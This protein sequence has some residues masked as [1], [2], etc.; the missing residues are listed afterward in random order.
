MGKPPSHP[1]IYGMF[2]EINQPAIGDPRLWHE[3]Q[4]H[5]SILTNGSGCFN[6]SESQTRDGL[7]EDSETHWNQCKH[8]CI[9]I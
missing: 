7:N 2:H 9:Y 8:V 5:R 6:V 3:D 1:F 4:D